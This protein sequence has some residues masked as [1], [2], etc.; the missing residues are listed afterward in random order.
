MDRVC[1]FIY[2]D[3]DFGE[4]NGGLLEVLKRKLISTN[5][6]NPQQ[7]I[8]GQ[9]AEHATPAARTAAF[10]IDKDW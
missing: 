9:L 4:R 5:D 7:Q 1:R 3:C 6:E 2:N 10:L 8:Q